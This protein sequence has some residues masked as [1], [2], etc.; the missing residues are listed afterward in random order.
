MPEGELD[1][2]EP[3]VRQ[4]GVTR[5][6]R[7]EGA[8]GERTHWRELGANAPGVIVLLTLEGR[9]AMLSGTLF[10]RD[11][12]AC[13]GQPLVSA[14]GEEARRVVDAAIERLRRA[15]SR[16]EADALELEVTLEGQAEGPRT[17]RLR[18]MTLEGAQP[19]GAAFSAF[20]TDI[21]EQAAEQQALCAREALLWRTQKSAQLAFMAGGLAHDFNNL[22]TV[23]VGAAD[24]LGEESPPG[25]VQR[26][27]LLQIQRAGERATE[28]T[29]Q[30]L[31]FSRREPS[32][33]RR[34]DLAARLADLEGLLLRMIG[35]SIRL[36]LSHDA[37]L[38]PVWFDP[39]H[40]EQVLTHLVGNAR[41][42][43]PRGG[44][45]TLALRNLEIKTF[46][47]HGGMMV[48]PGQYVELRVSDTGP[49]STPAAMAVAFE[50]FFSAQPGEVPT[51][52]SLALVRSLIV[53]S[54]G[55][56]WVES[57]PGRGTT[58][59]VLLPRSRRARSAAQPKP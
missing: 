48:G 53:Q 40:A 13:V 47:S 52:L 57:E 46:D 18:L 37:G 49:G 30:L 25:S 59:V 24:L 44:V 39:L 8:S 29:R 5:A 23:I 50:P 38:W 35:S 42:A 19:T 10:S 7:R 17:H 12:S 55:H 43:M 20:V 36:E 2:I 4:N 21:T 34:V 41:Q 32:V 45:L 14:L 15:A 11:A 51:D 16:G 22:L 27:E 1:N 31:A 6:A 58:F 33:P 54:L 28:I 9:V 26:A 3:R 56:V